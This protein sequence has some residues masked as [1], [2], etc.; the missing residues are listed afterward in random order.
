MDL[1]ALLAKAEEERASSHF[2]HAAKI[3]RQL[4]KHPQLNA[5]DRAQALLGLADMERIQGYFQEALRHYAQGAK[6]LKR[7]EPALYWDAQVGWALAARAC[8]R[9]KEALVILQRA[10]AFYKNQQD[11]SGEAFTHW[12]LGGT[13]RIAGDMKQGLQELLIALRAYKKHKE[14]EGTA[15]TCCALG[16]IY[17]MLGRYSDS[18]RF[19]KEANRRMRQRGDTFGIAYSYCGLGNVERMA[20]RFKKALPFYKKA[21]KLYA[22]IGDR[23]SYA[24]TLWSIG[25]TYKMLG[26]YQKAIEFF[27]KADLLFKKTGD[28]R[29]RIYVSQGLVEIGGLLPINPKMRKFLD[30]FSARKENQIPTKEFP[31]EDLH[32][33][34]LFYFLL[35]GAGKVLAKMAKTPKSEQSRL[36]KSA[37]DAIKDLKKKYQKAGS[38]FFPTTLPI[39]WP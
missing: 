16:G 4:S 1:E 5:I 37:A 18:G 14:P 28:T 8:G 36:R 25:T 34:A 10:L 31:W 13:Y 27:L 3:Y 7:T 11:T 32:E 17:R 22:T 30:K 6:S 35:I 15:Y 12:A 2:S 21:E 26:Q 29:G 24:Y 20:G 39:N 9:P 33:L 23:V 38:R 19:Y